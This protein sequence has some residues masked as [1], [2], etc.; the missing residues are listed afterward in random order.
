MATPDV[1]GKKRSFCMV[2]EAEEDGWIMGYEYRDGKK[3]DR[4][5]LV[6]VESV[7]TREE[8]A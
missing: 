1:Y 2:V 7:E 6:K 5:H 4:F 8:V 3:V